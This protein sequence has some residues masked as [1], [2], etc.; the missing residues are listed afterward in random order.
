MFC[1]KKNHFYFLQKIEKN[2]EKKI[3]ENNLQKPKKKKIKETN[4][5]KLTAGSY[6]DRL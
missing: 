1:E 2:I 4:L 5:E 6:G 3:Y